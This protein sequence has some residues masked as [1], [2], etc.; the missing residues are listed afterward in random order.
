MAYGTADTPDAQYPDR[1]SY[2]INPDGLV[3]RVY[4]QVEPGQH[5]EVVLRDLV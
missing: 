1:I 5:P 3:G 2:L 4:A